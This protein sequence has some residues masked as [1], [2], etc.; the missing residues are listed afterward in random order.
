MG[1]GQRLPAKFASAWDQEVMDKK[2]QKFHCITKCLSTSVKEKR[3][4][5]PESR[6][7]KN[8]G[9]CYK[10]WTK[11]MG[12]KRINIVTEHPRSDYS[13]SIHV[14][15]FTFTVYEEMHLI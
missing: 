11:N 12:K 4:K 15:T 7:C 6:D 13:L 3:Q 10:L 14:I 8:R 9:L 1:T 5:A 2:N